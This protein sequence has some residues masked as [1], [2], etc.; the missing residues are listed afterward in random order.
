LSTLQ[1]DITAR[2][3]QIRQLL[4]VT[5]NSL[6]SSELGYH[7]Q[8]GKE[9]DEARVQRLLQSSVSR[10]INLRK[11]QTDTIE[12]LALAEERE[13][14]YRHIPNQW[15]ASG[16]ITSEYGMRTSPFG[17]RSV[18]LHDGID[19][20]NQ[21]GT[22]VLAAAEGVVI[23]AGTMPAY[24]Y[25]VMIDHGNGLVTQ[26]G[27]N[28]RLRVQ[29]GQ[30]VSKGERIADMGNTGRSTG[31]HLHFSIYQQGETVNPREYLP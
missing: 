12:L 22:P 11:T 23:Y 15:P 13:R 24:G 19:I 16:T 18:S 7:G 20:A 14:Y 29:E 10:G 4:G 17:G 9:D 8:G 6:Q 5:E 30:E 21:V 1:E 2:Q 3:E 27:H 25:T 31:S 26:Y 28:S